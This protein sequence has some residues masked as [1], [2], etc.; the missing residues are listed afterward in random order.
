MTELPLWI[1]LLVLPIL[2]LIVGYMVGRVTG[3]Q[4]RDNKAKKDRLKQMLEEIQ[5]KVD[6]ISSLKEDAQS[7]SSIPFFEF[8]IIS[9]KMK[10]E[11]PLTLEEQLEK[12]LEEEDYEKAAQ[13]RNLI[14]N[15][16]KEDE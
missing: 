10:E 8:N 14:S 15:K 2:C 12:A 11:E 13:I 9:R 1:Y 5:G 16:N 3:W 6:D 7:F 4:L